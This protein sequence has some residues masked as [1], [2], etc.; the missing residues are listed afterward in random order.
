MLWRLQSR[1]RF[2]LGLLTNGNRTS[3]VKF[4]DVCFLLVT[5]R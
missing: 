1:L 4:V 5:G 3:V 2:D